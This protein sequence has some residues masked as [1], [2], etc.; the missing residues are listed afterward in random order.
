MASH[1]P[2]R[3]GPMR[4][5]LVKEGLFIRDPCAR[6]LPR[7]DGESRLLCA[8]GDRSRAPI[9]GT[10]PSSARRGRSPHLH[11]LW[12][13]AARDSGNRLGATR[14]AP[15]PCRS[16]RERASSPRPFSP[17]PPPLRYGG[18]QRESSGA[19]QASRRNAPVARS[20]FRIEGKALHAMGGDEGGRARESVRSHA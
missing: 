2:C 6:A 14:L 13:I 15:V 5:P 19:S 1:D 10:Q 16:R 12:S 7:G 17:S 20:R 9:P 3:D 4:N 11:E 8:P 18:P